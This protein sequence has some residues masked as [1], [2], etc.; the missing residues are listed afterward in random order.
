MPALASKKVLVGC[1]IPFSP[2]VHEGVCSLSHLI[3]KLP[4]K[5]VAFIFQELMTPGCGDK[6]FFQPRQLHPGGIYLCAS[7]QG[8]SHLSVVLV[9]ELIIDPLQFA[10]GQN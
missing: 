2:H 10:S 4:H 9:E 1:R 7:G 6:L 8:S 3:Q 5:L